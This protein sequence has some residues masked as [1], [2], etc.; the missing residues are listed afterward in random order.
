MKKISTLVSLI[1]ITII[2]TAC[3]NGVPASISI[4][5]E[6]YNRIA[7]SEEKETKENKIPWF[8]YHLTHLIIDL[9]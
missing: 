8:P 9:S 4:T 2:I 5:P 6:N 3:Q 1:I 7:I